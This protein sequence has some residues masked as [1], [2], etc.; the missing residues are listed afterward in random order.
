LD[1]K[2]AYFDW[3]SDYYAKHGRMMP[4]DG[5]DQLAQHDAIFLGAVGSPEV[6][7]MEPLWGF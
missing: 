4:A 3:G 1:L 7:D 5:V 2:F 6:P